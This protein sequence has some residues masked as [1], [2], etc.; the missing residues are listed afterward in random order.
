MAVSHIHSKGVVHRDIKDENIILD[1]ETGD[2]KLIDFGCGTLL[3][4][5]A[6]RDFSGTPEFYPPEWFTS[7]YYHAR[8]SRPTCMLQTKP[9]EAQSIIH[10][11]QNNNN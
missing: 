7:K 1:R 10:I 2:I 11:K 8:Y 4:E 9:D 6:Y 5:S 3:K